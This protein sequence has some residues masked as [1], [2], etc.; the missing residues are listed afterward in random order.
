LGKGIRLLR[1]PSKPKRTCEKKIKKKE[2]L[3][4]VNERPASELS[5]LAEPFGCTPQAV[6]YALKRMNI[7]LKKRPCGTCSA[8]YSE[9]R[10][11]QSQKKNEKS[12]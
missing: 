6:V 5:E 10:L 11:F 4:A 7:T 9:K 12:F 2:L 3:E 1:F 8:T